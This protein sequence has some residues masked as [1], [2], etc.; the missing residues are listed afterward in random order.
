MAVGAGTTA[1]SRCRSGDRAAPAGRDRQ[2]AEIRELEVQRIL[3]PL[4]GP[5]P[6]ET[7]R[8][9]R[10]D[11][12]RVHMWLP[13]DRVVPDVQVERNRPAMP[14]QPLGAPLRPPRIG[15]PGVAQAR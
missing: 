11:D 15:T 14:G 6:L 13:A 10:R 12:G 7:L 1:S 3:P 4:P 8:G 2:P 9:E 5:A